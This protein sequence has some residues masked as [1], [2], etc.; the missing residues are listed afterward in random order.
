MHIYIHTHAQVYTDANIY[1]HAH[2]CEW[3][4]TRVLL[5]LLAFCHRQSFYTLIHKI[6]L[7]D[8]SMY[9][10][11]GVGIGA[12]CIIAV[13]VVLVVVYRR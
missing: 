12:A 11:I 13:V 2:M 8:E 7:T 5:L 4:C 10:G 6:Y 1:T 3:V 9:I